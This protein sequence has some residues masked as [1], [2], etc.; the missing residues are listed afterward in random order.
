M[1]SQPLD[2]DVTF[3]E[4]TLKSRG[5][6]TSEAAKVGVGA[7]AGAILWGRRRRHR[8]SGWRRRGD[9]AAVAVECRPGCRRGAGRR[10]HPSGA[11]NPSG[12]DRPTLRRWRSASF[13]LGLRGSR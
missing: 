1:V 10:D 12:P 9:G 5:I 11:A 3:V 7:A 13:V 2:A 8:R 6:G 4:H